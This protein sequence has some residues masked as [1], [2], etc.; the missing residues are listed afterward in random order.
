MIL[1]ARHGLYQ[2]QL[3]Q[4]RL[5]RPELRVHPPLCLLPID[6]LNLLIYQAAQSDHI[7][8]L[9]SARP[10][11]PFFF[12]KPPSSILP[13]N[14]GPVLRPKGV[15]LHYEVELALI[16]GKEVKDLREDDEEGALSAIECVSL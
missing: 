10:K 3:P 13:P 4:S 15:D 6:D 11:K 16:L 1:V 9:N 2:S 12:L 5:H 14:S 7:K 8:E